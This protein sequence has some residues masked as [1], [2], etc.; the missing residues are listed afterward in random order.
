MIKVYW[1]NILKTFNSDVESYVNFMGPL[2]PSVR[3][4][5]EYARKVEQK[6]ADKRFEQVDVRIYSEEFITENI[7]KT[8]LEM[9][10]KLTLK[11]YSTIADSKLVYARGDGKGELYYIGV[12]WNHFNSEEGSFFIMSLIIFPDEDGP[13]LCQI[14]LGLYIDKKKEEMTQDEIDKYANMVDWRKL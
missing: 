5:Q 7:A 9:L 1:Q 12:N 6:K 11:D 4:L 14:E 10:D 3:K 8:A 2:K 13:M